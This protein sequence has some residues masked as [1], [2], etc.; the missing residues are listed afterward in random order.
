ML[1]EA[2]LDRDTFHSFVRSKIE[3]TKEIEKDNFKF[4]KSFGD[5]SPIN[6]SLNNFFLGVLGP[7]RL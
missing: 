7:N 6:E 5:I 4:S 3:L 2:G 1:V